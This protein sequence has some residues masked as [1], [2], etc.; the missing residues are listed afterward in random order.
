MCVTSIKELA[1]KIKNND[2]DF[3]ERKPVEVLENGDIILKKCEICGEVTEYK[4]Q[5][6]DMSRDCACMRSYRKQARLKRFKDLSIIDRNAGSNIFSNAEIDKSNTEE[7]KIYQELYKYAEDFSIE[8]H[9]YIFA[10]G[11]GTGKTFLANCVCNMLNERGFSV[12]SFSLG[13]Y[14]NRIRKNIDEEESFISAVK[15]V[16]LLFIDDLGSEYINR[17]NGKMWAEEKIFR[18]FDERYRAGKP[19]VITTNL[20][21][22]ELKE[23]LKINGVNKVYDRLLEMCKYVEFNWQSKRKL[24]LQR[25]YNK[26]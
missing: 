13:A 10:G 21:V 15:D 4:H 11:V 22:G 8:K 5:G 14:F 12:L 16:D 26:S 3:I 6:Y 25:L 2:F 7:R 23:H 24:K 20:K 17:E 9:G 1:E 19:I 18:L